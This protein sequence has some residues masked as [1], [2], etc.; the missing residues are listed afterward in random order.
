MS[1][2]SLWPWVAQG[3][4]GGRRGG[5]IC[6]LGDI[7]TTSRIRI[8]ACAMDGDL[9]LFF[10]EVII[11][12][13]DGYACKCWVAAEKR[14]HTHLLCLVL[15]SHEGSLDKRTRSYQCIAETLGHSAT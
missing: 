10:G 4:D 14:I 15:I 2:S 9:S 3:F 7:A 8:G 6:G 11:F 5:N 1:G 13:N 12:I